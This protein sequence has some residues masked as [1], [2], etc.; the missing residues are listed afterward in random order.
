MPKS[1]APRKAPWARAA[2]RVS[3]RTTIDRLGGPSGPG[4]AWC[5][6][7]RPGGGRSRRGCRP[8][9]AA[10]ASRAMSMLYWRTTGFGEVREAA[11][12]ASTARPSGVWMTCVALAVVPGHFACDR[13]AEGDDAADHPAAEGVDLLH[14]RAR[15]RS[16]ARRRRSVGERDG[17]VVA[18]DAR[19]VLQVELDRVDLLVAA[20]A[21]P[22][23]AG[24][25]VAHEIAVMW[26]A[27]TGLAGLEG[28]VPVALLP[29][30]SVANKSRWAS[31]TDP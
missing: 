24:S 4:S 3:R 16:S 27:R 30:A 31:T 1:E 26:T 6:G 10:A 19:L 7:G 2:S 25:S 5:R 17:R 22:A 29:A 18:D 14:G 21:A 13:V 20:A 28:H 8:R 15:G 23:R 12:A 9:R 11:V